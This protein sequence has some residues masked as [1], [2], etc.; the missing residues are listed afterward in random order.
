MATWLK[1][2]TLEKRLI[3][4]YNRGLGFWVIA[5]M[6]SEEFG[7]DFSVKSIDSRVFVLKEEGKLGSWVDNAKIGFLD[8]E[9][10]N[11][12]ANAGFMISW[13]I[14]FRDENKTYSDMITSKEITQGFGNDKRIVASLIEQIKLCDAIATFWG[15]GFDVP[16]MRARALDHG[17]DF[18]AYG[19]VKHLD[20][21]YT[22]RRIFKLH[23]RS[24][25]AVT[26]FLG[27]E[28]KTHL[29]LRIWNKGRVGHKPSM[30][31]ILEHNIADVEIL[32][33]LFERVKPFVAWNR[34][35]I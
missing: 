28:G 4:L 15:T 35:S 25:H 23:R 10:S 16:Y 13:A 7:M 14:Y 20:L 2:K 22:C 8:I 18:P 17:L 29:D 31:Y 34:K 30:D 12:D 5:E 21:F 32:A 26:E 24:L 33:A 11:F 19:S 3:E 6:L 1:N 27:I 9:T